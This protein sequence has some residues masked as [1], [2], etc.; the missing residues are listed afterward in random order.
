MSALTPAGSTR[1]WRLLRQDVL[2]RDGY[3]CHWCKNPANTV[4]HLIARAR[5]GT[6]DPAN[7]VAACLACNSRRGQAEANI[8]RNAPRSREW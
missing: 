1:R 7:L 5:G 3:R 6:D 8:P 4:D 2:D